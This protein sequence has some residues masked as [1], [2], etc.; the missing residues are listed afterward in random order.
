M[1]SLRRARRT[2]KASRGFP[3]QINEYVTSKIEADGPGLALALASGTIIHTAAFGLANVRDGLP[4]KEDTI[5]HLASCGK[6]FTG[7]GILM[8]AGEGKLHLDDPVCKH[9]PL[10]A[11]FGPA[12]TIRKLLHHT[13][14]IQ[15]FYGEDCAGQLLARCARPCNA[16]L[17][18]TYAE[19]GCPMAGQHIEPG[20]EF[21]YSNSG[22]ELLGAVIEGVSG[23]PY[24]EF[25]ASRVFGPLKMINTFSAPGRAIDGR[26]SATGYELGE[27]GKL[28]EAGTS[29]FDALVG[30]GSFYAAV[31]DLCL[32]D[33]ALRTNS[34]VSE[35]S[36]KEAFTPGRTNDGRSTGYGFGWFLESQS[37][38]RFADHPGTW[39]GFRSYIRYYLDRP[40]SIF[41]LS[42]HPEADLFEI[43]DTAAEGCR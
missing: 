10:I 17:I 32:Y 42:N 15:D 27:R 33:R 35:S 2:P 7:L 23:Q 4:V 28:R 43:A 13:S 37:G 16:D 31:P 38:T 29:E 30:A 9:L 34:L 8:L 40:L 24:H 3:A 22:Y 25:F 6:Q 14:G 21:C 20:D 5:F 11:G 12:V 18:R 1:A 41:L 36:I 19:L 26:R 39:N